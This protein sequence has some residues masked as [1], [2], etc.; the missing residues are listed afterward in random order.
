MT[1]YRWMVFTNCTPGREADFN[2]WYDEVHIADLLR[3]PGIDRATRSTLSQ[4]QATMETGEIELCGPERIGARFRYLAI[5]EF[6]ADDPMTVLK[7]I[8][9]RANTPQ[10]LIT[11]DLADVYTVLYED[12]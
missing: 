4:A 5:Y 3:V 10:M 12:S 2:R 7:E 9:T 1:R 8:Q 11:P 6:A